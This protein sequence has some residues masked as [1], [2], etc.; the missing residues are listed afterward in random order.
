M[1]R[2]LPVFQQSIDAT[3]P[4]AAMLEHILPL[5]KKFFIF[6]FSLLA[7]VVLP[8]CES[9]HDDDHSVTSTTTTE[10]TSLHPSAPAATSTTTV[11][12][13]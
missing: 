7:L 8:A 2:V 1:L 6:G 12:T 13:Y 4:R 10:E 11:R 3:L 5:M 9:G